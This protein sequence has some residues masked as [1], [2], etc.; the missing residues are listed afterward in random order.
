MLNFVSFKFKSVNI[1][2]SNKFNLKE[3][4]WP[5]DELRKF[6]RLNDEGN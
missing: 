3:E 6:L 1:V 2:K 4:K 5:A